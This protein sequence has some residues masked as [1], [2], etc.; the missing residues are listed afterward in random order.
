M[1]PKTV[2]SKRQAET[3]LRLSPGTMVAWPYNN[4]LSI[5]IGWQPGFTGVDNIA[6]YEA[7]VIN[8]DGK[9][10][11][12]HWTTMAFFLE[13]YENFITDPKKNT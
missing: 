1:M 6:S 2:C 3:R 11:T 4:C 7:I 5:I 12:V 13:R 8:N 9:I 10:D